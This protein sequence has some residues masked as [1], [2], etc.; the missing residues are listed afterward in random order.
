MINQVQIG[1]EPLDS[2][3]IIIWNSWSSCIIAEVELIIIWNSWSSCIIAESS[4]LLFGPA[5]G[6]STTRAVVV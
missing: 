3:I 6:A 2:N 1:L 4:S 5:I